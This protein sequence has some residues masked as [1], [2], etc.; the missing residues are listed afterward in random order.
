MCNGFPSLYSCWSLT[1]E[2]TMLRD[3]TFGIFASKHTNVYWKNLEVDLLVLG[4]RCRSMCIFNFNFNWIS[5]VYGG[6]VFI[7]L[8]F[9]VVVY[10][11]YMWEWERTNEIQCTVYD[12]DSSEVPN[13]CW[14]RA[15]DGVSVD[16]Q[17]RLNWIILAKHTT[18]TPNK[19][20]FLLFFWVSFIL[21]E[22]SFLIGFRWKITTTKAIKTTL[23][24]S[25]LLVQQLLFFFI[26]KGTHIP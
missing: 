24:L 10:L 19:K 14:I 20:Q 7:R 13:A 1:S 16:Q 22:V 25:D 21:F 15:T 2:Q 17:L 9:V 8:E 3:T 11:D 5:I 6:Y 26:P 4:Q 12:D 23:F 18:H